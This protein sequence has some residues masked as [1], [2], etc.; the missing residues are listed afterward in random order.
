MLSADNLAHPT[1]AAV[2]ARLDDGLHQPVFFQI[3]RELQARL[4]ALLDGQALQEVW[5][6]KY[7]HHE[8]LGI[9]ADAAQVHAVLCVGG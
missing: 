6:Y 8:G 5:A 2:Q 4:P 3:A 1:L 7:L 9:H